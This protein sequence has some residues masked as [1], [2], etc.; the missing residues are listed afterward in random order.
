MKYFFH[1]LSLTLFVI[2]LFPNTL[3]AQQGGSLDVLKLETKDLPTGYQFTEKLKC[4]STQAA[5]L[6]KNINTYQ[7]ELGGVAHASYQSVIGNKDSGSILY[8]QFNES[9]DIQAFLEQ[10][11]WGDKGQPS[12]TRPEE[13]AV[14]GKILIIWSTNSDSKIKAASKRKI[15]NVK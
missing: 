2:L 12:K 4:R 6:Y 9:K 14:Y 1:I 13:Y 3:H 8:F 5:Q 11:L 15:E 10:H 7:Q